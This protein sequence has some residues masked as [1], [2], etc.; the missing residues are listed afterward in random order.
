M[1]DTGFKVTGTVVAD[2]WTTAVTTARIN[3]SDDSRSAV[4]GIGFLAAEL[5]NFT[6]GIPAGATIDGIEVQ[7]EISNNTGGQIATLQISLSWYK[8]ASYTATKSDTQTGTTDSTKTYGG[9]ADTWGRS[10]SPDTEMADGT[11]RIKIEG[12]SNS[13]GSACRLD[14]LAIKIYYTEAGTSFVAQVIVI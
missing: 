2:A 6:F 10:W 13:A 9:A 12:K 1:A 3:T 5:E 4:L 8:G 11:F 14:Y 7:G